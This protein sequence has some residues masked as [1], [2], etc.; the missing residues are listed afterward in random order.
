MLS[1]R[2]QNIILRV[3]Q[4]RISII[5][6]SGPES[7]IADWLSRYNHEENKDEVIN[8]LDIRVDVVQVVTNVPECMSIQQ[9]QQATKQDEH[10]QRLQHFIITCWPDA[11]EQLHQDTKPYQSIKDDMSVIDGV[12][13]KGRCIIIPKVLQ[14]EA[15][16]Q[17]HVN[18]MGI[19]ET[20]LLAYESVYW[21]NINADIKNYIKIA[22]LVLNSSQHR[23][24]K[25]N[26]S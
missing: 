24:R 19:E 14:Q 20:K 1:Q 5:Y 13:M 16:D 12:I 22:I 10:L 6:K 8:G 11:R 18:Y 23:L 26:T 9:I 25:N 7:F 17:L 21:V 2:I 3:H 4:Y 15:L